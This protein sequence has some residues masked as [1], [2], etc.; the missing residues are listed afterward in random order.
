V[1]ALA[2]YK[3]NLLAITI[4]AIAL[5]RPA[6]LRGAAPV[7]IALFCL[8][9]ATVGWNGFADYVRVPTTPAGKQALETPPRHKF[10]GL[11]GSTP[12]TRNGPAAIVVFGLATAAA[13]VVAIRW[14]KVSKGDSAADWLALSLLATLSLLGNPYLPTYDLALLL[15]AGVFFAEGMVRKYGDSV[16]SRGVLAHVLIALAFFG[17]HLSQALAQETGFQPFAWA[18]VPIA[19]WQWRE[20]TS[21][22]R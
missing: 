18:L 6:I 14:R 1:L 7:V 12:W 9:V 13:L 19:V 10:H 11:A 4:A 17:P 2:A 20:F 8:G 3:P 21:A 15:P 22:T 5:K 16:G